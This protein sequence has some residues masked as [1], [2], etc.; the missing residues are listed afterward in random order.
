MPGRQDTS[1]FGAQQTRFFYELTPERMLDAVEAHG[2]RLT[3]RAMALNSMENRVYQLEIEL[4]DNRQGSPTS[5]CVAKFYRPGRWSREQLLEEHTFLADLANEEIPVVPPLADGDGETLHLDESTGIMFALFPRVG[6]RSPDE[7][8][9]SQLA[10]LGRLLAR[11]H[12]VGA[13]RRAEHRLHITP[14]SYGLNNLEW[15]V[16][17]DELPTGVCDNYR[18]TVETI[19]ELSEPWFEEVTVQRIH[20]DCHLANVLWGGQGLFLVDFDDMLVGP[21]VQDLWLLVPGRDDYARGQR[22]RLLEAYEE[23]RDFDRGSLRLVEVLR[24]LRIVH[25]SAW[26]ARRWEDPAFQKV[27]PDFGS[28]RYWFEELGILQEQLSLVREQA[29]G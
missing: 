27:F 12:N 6:G 7:L 17:N 4:E 15:L 23:M 21:P 8:D 9:D 28:D 16:D 20:G 24:A 5:F 26:I 29:W 11:L 2:L 10:Q 22:E 25:F 18:S 19:C 13:T 3:G 1:A 14:R